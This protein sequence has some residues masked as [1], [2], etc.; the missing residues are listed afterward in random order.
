LPLALFG[1][2]RYPV[3]MGRLALPLLVAMAV[4]PFIAGLAFQ[5][6]GL[7]WTLSLLLIIALSNVLLVVLLTMMALRRG[8]TPR[9]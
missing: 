4:A 2:E 3:L 9:S 7:G 5:R 6:G 8:A 1:P